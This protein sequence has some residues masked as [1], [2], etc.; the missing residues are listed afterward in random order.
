MTVTLTDGRQMTRLRESA[1]GDYQDPYTDDEIRSKFRGLAGMV[2]SPAGV[3]RVEGLVDR[4]DTLP[5]LGDL[6]AAVRAGRG[7]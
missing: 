4:L 1:R 5:R 3:A 7:A 2:L 6:V